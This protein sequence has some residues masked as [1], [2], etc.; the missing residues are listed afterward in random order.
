MHIV[1]I[2]ENY[3]SISEALKDRTGV[4]VLGFFFQVILLPLTFRN[5]MLQISFS[6][7]AKIERVKTAF[8]SEIYQIDTF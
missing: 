3:P 1:H 6:L 7:R 4:A 5:P 2:K 8:E